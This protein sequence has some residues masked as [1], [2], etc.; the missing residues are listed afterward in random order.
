M[1]WYD[2]FLRFELPNGYTPAPLDLSGV[3]LSPTLEKVIDLLAQNDHNVWSKEHIKQGW[4]YG[5][6]LVMFVAFK[7]ISMKVKRNRT[8]FLLYVGRESQAE[9]MPCALQP[10]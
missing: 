6:Q 3:S 8:I 2:L 10:T 5:A 9:S 7:H 4:T 1:N